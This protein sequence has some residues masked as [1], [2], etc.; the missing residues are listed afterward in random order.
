[1][2]GRQ[3]LH[4]Q[5]ATITLGSVSNELPWY[6]IFHMYCHNLLLGYLS[7]YHGPALG[8]DLE[9]CAWLL[10]DF[11]PYNF[12]FADFLLYPFTVIN[13]FLMYFLFCYH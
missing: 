7:A 5:S 6:A 3:C 4:D 8:E 12:S 11:S 10:P 9:I 2:L 13:L 1:M